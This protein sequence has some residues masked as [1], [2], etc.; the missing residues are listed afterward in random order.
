[1]NWGNASGWGR[2]SLGD[3]CPDCIQKPVNCEL[4]EH[5]GGAVAGG[6]QNHIAAVFACCNDGHRVRCSFEVRQ[7]TEVT[8]DHREGGLERKMALK[9][10]MTA[11]SAAALCK[12]WIRP[13]EEVEMDFVTF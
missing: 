8:V 11:G 3:I 5:I 9:G 12:R 2:R 4:F 10:D 6:C 7:V 13:K 1:M